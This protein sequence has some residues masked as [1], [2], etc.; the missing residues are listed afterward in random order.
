MLSDSLPKAARS[1]RFVD[2]HRVVVPALSPASV[3]CPRATD[4]AW[5]RDAIAEIRADAHRSA[6]THL[7]RVNLP[8]FQR[9]GVDFYLKGEREREAHRCTDDDDGMI[10][11]RWTLYRRVLPPHRVVEAPSGPFALPLRPGQS[12]GQT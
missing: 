11:Q 1:T 12:L 6:D 2:G 5:I 4:T 3:T 8:A 7:F 10:A 9:H